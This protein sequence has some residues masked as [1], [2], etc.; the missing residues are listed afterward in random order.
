MFLMYV[1][2]S[3][4]PG[5]PPPHGNS[6]TTHFFLSG[7]IVH[8]LDWL[9]VN[10]ELLR[11]R[12]WLKGRYGIYLDDELHTTEMFGRSGSLPRSL[13]RLHKH[14]R[15]AILRHQL[16]AIAA[17]HT[18]RVI[19]VVVD[20]SRC[21]D[22]QSVFRKAWYVLFQRFENTISRKNFPNKSN[23]HDRGLVFPDNTSAAILKSHLDDMR[24]R[25]K[26]LVRQSNGVVQTIDEPIK[27]I[28][29]DPV[30]RD[31]RHS[32]FVQAADCC[33]FAFKQSVQ[34]NA[35]M[36]KHGGNAYFR[37]R[38]EPVLCK[39]ASNQDPLGLGVARV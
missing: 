26:L 25:N 33:V 2:E 30:C 11:F 9:A 5:V 17:I 19:N 10:L 32:F 1:D 37:K 36:K 20:K 23:E 13:Q 15:L 28:V 31:S 35:F 8:E 18:V 4:D 6:P 3:G 22:T 27:L 39:Q 34:P 16:D 7:L 24:Q 12:H 21:G 38:L 29:E 14:E